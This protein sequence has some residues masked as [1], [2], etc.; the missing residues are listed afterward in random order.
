MPRSCSARVTSG[1][2]V[3]RSSPTTTAPARCAS[4]ARAPSIAAASWRT[5]VPRSGDSPGGIHHSR[6]NP[7]TWFTRMPSTWR[8]TPR[9]TSRNG[10]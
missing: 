3:L 6:H 9:S 1:S 10:W 5:Y 4:K 2:T 7:A 8:S